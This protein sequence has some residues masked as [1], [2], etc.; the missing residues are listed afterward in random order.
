M[1]MSQFVWMLIGVSVV[2]AVPRV[3][4]MMLV[5]RFGMPEWLQ[6]WLRYVPPAVMVA[7]IAQSVLTEGETFVPL[8]ENQ[9]LVALIPTLI[10]AIWTRSL[11]VTVLTGIGSMLVLQLW[12]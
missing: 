11:L 10:A 12:A 4:P 1:E 7:L 3:L 2:T 6:R 5:S 8:H 9:N